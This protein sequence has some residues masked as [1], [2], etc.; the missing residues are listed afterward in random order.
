MD[1]NDID[2]CIEH[3]TSSKSEDG[4]I[5][6]TDDQYNEFICNPKLL[7]NSLVK[8]DSLRLRI[9]KKSITTKSILSTLVCDVIDSLRK[10]NLTYKDLYDINKKVND[11]EVSI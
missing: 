3:I 8:I 1:D 9:D 10:R 5:D 4:H 6:I 7:I 2:K 11:D